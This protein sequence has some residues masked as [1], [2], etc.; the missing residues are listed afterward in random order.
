MQAIYNVLARRKQHI[1]LSI[2]RAVK[3]DKAT[4]E[5]VNAPTECGAAAASLGFEKVRLSK[6]KATSCLRH[7]ENRRTRKEFP[8]TGDLDLLTSRSTASSLRS[9]RFATVAISTASTPS[10][11]RI[12]S[13][14]GLVP[15]RAATPSNTKRSALAHQQP[16][17]RKQ[18]DKYG[19]AKSSI[20][21]LERSTK[22][23]L[24]NPPNDF[25]HR[26]SGRRLP[27]SVT[28]WDAVPDGARDLS[29]R[30]SRT[31]APRPR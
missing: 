27:I 28:G 8:V 23:T 10:C 13:R 1:N 29:A 14:P 18:V 11:T 30:K 3:Y 22:A 12:L 4:G 19:A 15:P 17:R 2:R 9:M 20:Q 26:P 25:R 21:K 7:D 16:N 5:I 24:P 31:F 6:A